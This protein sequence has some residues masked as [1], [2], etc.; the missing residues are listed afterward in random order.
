MGNLLFD[1]ESLGPRFLTIFPGPRF[2][3]SNEKF[4]KAY[5]E[6]STTIYIIFKLFTLVLLIIYDCAL[7]IASLDLIYCMYILF[8]GHCLTM[9]F[10]WYCC[11]DLN[12]ILISII[13]TT[14]APYCR[15]NVYPVDRF[16][17]LLKVSW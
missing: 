5:L 3:K 8:D 6:I 2:S 13:G 15:Q 17:L 11:V 10:S 12:I 16:M 1:F 9:P 14:K 4:P 7:P